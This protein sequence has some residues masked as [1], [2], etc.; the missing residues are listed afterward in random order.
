MKEKRTNRLS[1]ERARAFP[2]EKALAKL[3]HFPTKENDKEAWFLSPFRL[4][5]QASF[6]VSKTLNRWYD[7]GEGTGGNVI[8]LV[9]K[10]S[11]CTVKEAL[12]IIGEDKSSFLFQQ[13]PSFKVEQQDKIFV[14]EVKELTHY[15][16]RGYLSSRSISTATAK[17]YISEVHYSFKNKNY[18]AIGFKNDSGG[19]ELRNKYYKNCSSPKDITH[20]KKGNGKLIVTEGVFD[21]LSLLSYNEILEA[22]YDFSVLNSTA[23]V[24]KAMEIMK[25]YLQIDLYLDN[26]TNGKRT[27]ERLMAHSNNC[28]DK[29]MLY[30]G[31]KDMN[32]WLISYSKKGLGQE[33]RDVSLL[34]QR[35]TRFTPGGRKVREK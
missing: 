7:H 35:Q 13:R 31:F 30:Q 14:K 33:A 28:L 32:E 23:F 4:E 6:K 20:I 19:W 25:G 3:G 5:T 8:D 2:I 29:S 22:E 34:P 11:Q 12:R 15:A 21:L 27:T 26:D 18:F 17:K 1:C 9:C 10:I 16:L 24:S